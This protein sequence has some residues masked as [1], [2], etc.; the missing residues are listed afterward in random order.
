[1]SSSWGQA[2]QSNKGQLNT[3]LKSLNYTKV[4]PLLQK[5]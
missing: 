1:M 3:D 5:K 4:V 2:L